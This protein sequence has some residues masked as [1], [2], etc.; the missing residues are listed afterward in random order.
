MRSMLLSR[1]RERLRPPTDPSRRT[2]LFRTSQRGFSSAGRRATSLAIA[3][4]G[5]VLL[6]SV[7]VPAGAQIAAYDLQVSR[8]ADRSSPAPL[9]GATVA[10]PIYVFVPSAA[11]IREVRFYL[12]DTGRVGAP[13]QIEQRAPWDFAG[14][15]TTGTAKPFNTTGVTDGSHVITAVLLR[16]DGSTAVQNATFTVTNGSALQLKVSKSPDR[17]SSVPLDGAKLR[18]NVYIFVPATPGI[19][20]VRFYL[21]DP[22]T[23]TPRNVEGQAP[24]DFAG[25]AADGTA[26][27]FNVDPLAGSPHTA[28]A[29]IALSNGTTQS[30]SGT[31][32]IGGLSFT[33]PSASFSLGTGETG[34][35]ETV[36]AAEGGVATTFSLSDSASWLTATPATGTTPAT[37]NVS[38]DTSGLAAGT[39]T[40]AVDA[41]S[42]AH[43]TATLTVTLTVG[44]PAECSPLACSEILVQPPYQ[45]G[46]G[47]DHGKIRDGAGV[48]T[49]LTYV[50]PPKSGSGYL[51]GNLSMQTSG[52]VLRVTT[53]K[54]LFQT[55]ANSQDNALG[56]GIDAPSQV[57]RL[58][59]TLVDPPSGTGNYEQAGLWFGN[60]QDNYVKLV[61]ISTPTGTRVETLMERNAATVGSRRSAALNLTAARVTLSLRADPVNRSIA[62][63]YQ[64]NGGASQSLG[65]FTAAPEFFS[66][67][68]A[69]ID[70]R[71]GTRSFGGILA[72]HRNGPAPVVYSFDEF[73]MTK[74]ALPPPPPSPPGSG[75]ISFN[76]SSFPLNRPTSMAWGPDGRLYVTE[77]MGRIHAITLGTNKQPIADQ[78][79]TTLGQ[80]LTL[81]IAVDPLS[82]PSNV[83]L[84]VSHSSPS[85][86]DG[87]PNSSTVTRLSGAAFTTRQDVITGLP[88]AKANHAINS[89]HFGPDGRLYIAQGGNTGAGAPNSANTEFGTME[90]QPLSA[91]ILV[92]DVRSATF[93]GSCHNPTDIFGPPPCDVIPYATGLRNAYDFVF[94]SNGS[95]YAPDNGL[96][97]TG[98]FPPSPA[99]PC[100]GYGDPALW[101]QGGDN[102]GEQPDTLL[103]VEQG[104]YYGHPNPYRNECVFGDGH[105]QGVSALQTYQA[106]IHTFGMNR[107][108]NGTIEYTSNA[109]CGDLKG[110]LL[111]A[112]YSVGDDITSIKLSASGTSVVSATQLRGGFDDPL[113]LTLGP[114]G[115]IYVGEYGGSRITALQPVDSGCWSTKKP[116]PQSVLDAGGAALD[117]RLYVVAGKTSGGHQT[118]M[119]IYDPTSDTWSSGP[120]L[121]GPAVEN[122]ALVPHDGKLYVFGGSTA[123]FSGAVANASVFD[124]SA[125]SW[126]TL[127]PMAVARGGAT[128]QVLGGRIYVAGGMGDDG[129]S[130]A[131]VEIL[132][133]TSRTWSSAPSMP[134]R[135]DNPGSAVL[136][137]K[138]Y[139]FG[140]RI[141]EAN[142]ST[143]NGALT[144]V[145]MFD[146]VAST[147]TARAPMPTGRR[148]VVVGTIGGRAQIMGGE[149]GGSAAFVQNEE[150][151]PAADS[152]RTLR[153]MPTGRHGAAAATIGG[154]VYVAGG[155]PNSGTS[156]TSVLEAFSFQ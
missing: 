48:G 128:A 150:Y 142:G 49:G 51:P 67:D 9:E 42:A 58:G 26:K 110:N 121:P 85:L 90:E 129:A 122:P 133:P 102:P 32:T 69:G 46:F 29:A 81:G 93:D 50:A 112:N 149:G 12:D 57:T 56:V 60:D 132:D 148:A 116:M 43:G 24:W 107:S 118:T 100:F 139:V 4:V 101:T 130:L 114:D 141:R 38:V 14:T 82:T 89:I 134:T 103:R 113:P 10:G 23:G 70:P 154:V 16:S 75:G 79:I 138:F 97:V 63:S 123:P 11:D 15:T 126:A 86:N 3:L 91:A 95:M 21:D 92:A 111:F 39:Y 37:I 136:N 41:T 140:G 2:T 45:L 6:S 115:T 127:P 120:A 99:P 68:A 31:F 61:V 40:A 119:Y 65:S 52:G 124:P 156:F 146:P 84:W 71:I 27:P 55:T 28:T 144:S 108:T 66:F 155:G 13:R 87:A 30:I 33:P 59:A 131:S 76:T 94:H 83:I 151:D 105:F 125:G 44:G 5:G 153:A 109:F 35:S 117:G 96:G 62:A 7:G 47:S 20:G 77:L 22:G 54:G 25:T 36:L 19:T 17:S 145:E 143:V 78:V 147:W 137:G 53:T 152:W 80:R 34:S 88:R 74:E 72:S 73:S 98:T 8:S 104:K 64:I 1:E 106:P 18:G 135:R